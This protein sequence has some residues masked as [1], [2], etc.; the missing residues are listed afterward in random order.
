VQAKMAD[1]CGNLSDEKI[2]ISSW[3]PES[4]VN[5]KA[6]PRKRSKYDQDKDTE[7]K[8]VYFEKVAKNNQDTGDEGPKS[9]LVRK[10]DERDT[11]LKSNKINDSKDYMSWALSTLARWWKGRQ[12]TL[13]NSLGWKIPD[14]NNPT[15]ILHHVSR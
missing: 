15:T 2:F 5:S 8:H 1:D 6:S 10:P 4:A 9:K 11:S 13:E 12:N 14:S 3:P 7:P